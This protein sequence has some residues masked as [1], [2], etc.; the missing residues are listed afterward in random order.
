[1]TFSLVS[2]FRRREL[3]SFADPDPLQATPTRHDQV[4]QKKLKKNKIKT[5]NK[6]RKTKQDVDALELLRMGMF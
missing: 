4:L 1:L 6:K 3:H 5:I 2:G